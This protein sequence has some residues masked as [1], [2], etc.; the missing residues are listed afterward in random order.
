MKSSAMTAQSLNAC[1]A[2]ADGSQREVTLARGQILIRR[3]LNGIDM[4]VGVPARAYRGVV[5][6][7]LQS[8]S[9]NAFYRINLWHRD[10]DLAVT[11]HEALDDREIVAEWKSW[12]KYFGLPKFIER[13]P[14]QIE[15]AEQNL[16]A[17][18]LGRGWKI[19]RRG[20]ALSKRRP[21]ILTRRK[22]GDASRMRQI[23]SDGIAVS[24]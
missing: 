3:R 22:T 10:P 24:E 2:R 8:S 18:A 23:C 9:G 15:G 11:L 12:A 17:V 14:G 4:K 13:E 1:D 5:L 19:R 21:R 20:A 6:S 16:G 7:L